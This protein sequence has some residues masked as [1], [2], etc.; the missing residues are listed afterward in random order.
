MLT[1]CLHL[2]SWLRVSGTLPLIP[3]YAF[4]ILTR[5]PP[6]YCH[7]HV[8][9]LVEVINVVDI[10]LSSLSLVVYVCFLGHTNFTKSLS[11]FLFFWVGGGRKIISSCHDVGWRSH[12]LFWIFCEP[13]WAII[14][15]KRRNL[16]D[17]LSSF[18]IGI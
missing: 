16:W 2:V 5:T 7:L 3:L 4:V 9:G 18:D 17:I 1:T 13:S 8:L 11:F 15:Y 6:H 10:R 14:L 12:F